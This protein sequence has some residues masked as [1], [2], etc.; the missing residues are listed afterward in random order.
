MKKNLLKFLFVLLL[1]GSAAYAQ[2][3]TIT[4]TVTGK[5]DGLPI[6][7]VTVT[8]TG[9]KTG[10]VTNANGAYTIK[11]PQSNV[12]LV[13][14]S[15]GY[16]TQTISVVGT[17]A[18][19]V[20]ESNQK[21]L[22]E[23]LVVGYGTQTKRENVGSVSQI[24]GSDIAETP[25]QNFEQALG[26]KAA[27]VQITVPS[28]VLNTPPVFHIRGTNSISLSS[29]PLIVVDGVVT[30]TGDFSG[31]E[32]GGNALSNVN[33]DDIETI[34][35]LKDA[36]A[37][38]IYGS[39]GA[40]GVV[41]ITTKKGKKGTSTVTIDSWVGATKPMRIPQVLDAFQYVALKNEAM[42]NFGVYNATV[43]VPQTIPLEYTT[44]TPDANGNPIN[45][46][47][48]KLI[49]RTGNT[50]NSN[51][52][53]SGGT[54]KTTYYGS[55]N[56]TKQQ[57]II[58]KN[59]FV[60]KSMLF[61]LD[62]KANKYLSY[63]AKL[64]Y[65]DQFNLA[66]TSSGSLSGEAYATAGLGR[67]A[68][69]L[70]PNLAPYLND[71]TYNLNPTGAG[72][73]LMNNKGYSITYPNPIP[74]LD[75]DRANNELNHTA[76]NIYMTVTPTPW[77]T[78]KS[79]YGIDYI[80]STNDNFA[81][82]FSNFTV[83]GGVASNTASDNNTYSQ[84]KRWD[85]VNTASFD[86]TFFG[87]HS[88]SLLLGNEQQRSTSSGF[89]LTRSILS[90][91]LF[92]QINS[93]YTNVSASGTSNS[94]NYLVSFFGRFNYNF[95]QKYFV[96]ATLR[97]DG[98]SG[99]GPNAKYGIFPGVGAGWEIAKEKFWKNI[100]AD[101]VVS[102]LKLKGSYGKT[103]NYNVGDFPSLSF[104]GYGLYNGIPTL[105]PSATGNVNLHWESTYKSDLGLSY[106]LFNDRITG[107]IDLY[108]NDIKD[109]IFNVPSAPSAGLAGSPLVNVGSMY[110][111]GVEFDINADI[112]RNAA[113]KWSANFNISFNQN[114]VTSLFPGTTA[115]YTTTSSLETANV[116]Q[117]GGSLSDLYIIR[118][119]GVDP[120]NGRRI[121]LNAAGQPIEYTFNGTQH[122]YHPDGTPYLKAD[123][124]TPNTINQTAD[125]V[126]YGNS[127]PKYIGGFSNTFR[128]K[129]FDL[130]VLLTFNLGF[131]TYYGTGATLTD[132]RFWNN[133]TD[134]LDHWTTPGQVA[135]FPRVVFGDNVSNG[136][137]FPTDFNTY[138]GNFLKIKSANIGYTL[139]KAFLSKLGIA[140]VRFYLSSYNLAIFTKYP[141]PDPEVSSNGTGNLNQ[142]VDRNTVAN[143]RTVTAG[144]SVKF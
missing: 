17:K 104:Y 119:A 37:T 138:N 116:T 112:V 55:V 136:T 5:D 48:Q 50:Y 23:V 54:D 16:V 78:I 52:S 103:G 14:S 122:W 27:G 22:N 12:S 41:V 133:S 106:G 121:F 127:V 26:G 2:T 39:R 131:Y 79:Q 32:S 68:L 97:R 80:Y 92:N 94:E 99:F 35:V 53:L 102:S 132:Q 69:L 100:G 74:S 137:S 9:T 109:L 3:K 33:P 77:I 105:G 114:K 113:F 85:W 91:P 141:G 62:H 45:T 118:T 128:Y 65:A 44:I 73:G 115:L 101:K 83:T 7:G 89:G 31:G 110:N 24:K 90:D 46:N 88:V 76:G 56:Y 135:K 117:V 34:D 20:L 51:I 107:E 60:S 81:N 30:F 42:V 93:G 98:Y 18:D 38:A 19:V 59:D 4:G 10:T 63:G 111:Q 15:I 129:S 75:M 140:N 72:I 143:G 21:A 6:P 47:W 11:A 28:G 108:K 13:F 130:S 1:L 66:A 8:V 142:G 144:V 49:Y 82:P 87:K 126:D 71:G 84:N 139:P 40:N 95:D 123:G 134:I 86:Y 29:Q 36:A 124:V 58:N 67:V 43:T 120:A 125:A 96:T 64:S 61:N 25:V 70:P 57:G